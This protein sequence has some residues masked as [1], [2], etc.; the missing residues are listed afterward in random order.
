MGPDQQ[1]TD[2]DHL[3]WMSKKELIKAISSAP[4]TLRSGATFSA[5]A[6]SLTSVATKG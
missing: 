6:S 4:A 2:E 1:V 3:I 5:V